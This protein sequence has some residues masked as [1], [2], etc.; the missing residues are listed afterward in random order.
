[1]QKRRFLSVIFAYTTW[2]LPVVKSRT[3][4]DKKC[5]AWP[6]IAIQKVN[7][8]L[9]N[10]SPVW[11]CN[12]VTLSTPWLYL[13]APSVGGNGFAILSMAML[14]VLKNHPSC[15]NVQDMLSWGHWSYESIIFHRPAKSSVLKWKNLLIS[16]AQGRAP[17]K[18]AL[19]GVDAHDNQTGS[20]KRLVEKMAAASHHR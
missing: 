18:K 13:L 16:F 15:C 7:H 12:D 11:R 4:K 14:L 10:W 1:M 19:L 8:A 20:R 3:V 2:L 6:W 9:S 5:K 17:C